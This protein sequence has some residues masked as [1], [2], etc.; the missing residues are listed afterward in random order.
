MK[1]F[2]IM[3]DFLIPKMTADRELENLRRLSNEET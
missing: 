1:Y 2:E 3:N